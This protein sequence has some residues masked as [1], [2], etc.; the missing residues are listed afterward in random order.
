MCLLGRRVLLAATA[1]ALSFLVS[2]GRPA[3]AQ[4]D[5][6]AGGEVENRKR[7]GKHVEQGDR[8]KEAGEYDKAAR[9]YEKAYD[10]V[11]HPELFFNLAQVYRLG[12]K[13]EKALEYYEKYLAVQ[14]NGRAAA[15]S[16]R[17]ARQLRK[18]LDDGKAGSGS[19]SQSGSGSRSGSG[20]GAGSGSGSGSGSG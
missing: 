6:E 19:G 2:A 20:S 5:E 1:L 14:P 13:K 4:D 18:Q 7:A 15:Q 11:P 12:G 16:K 17:F 9:E 8:Y 10:L 3:W